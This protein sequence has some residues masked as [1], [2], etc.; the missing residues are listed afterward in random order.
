MVTKGRRYTYF[1]PALDDTELKKYIDEFSG[2]VHS[3]EDYNEVSGWL[4]DELE[5]GL[6]AS[7]RDAGRVAQVPSPERAVRAKRYLD[8]D[9]PPQPGLAAANLHLLEVG[10][11]VQKRL[12]T[13]REARRVEQSTDDARNR[14]AQE[15]WNKWVAAGV[16]ML[17]EIRA[18][19]LHDAAGAPLPY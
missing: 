3:D 6:L 2:F 4:R 1:E 7:A 12:R 10:Q 17:K 14:I 11:P 5:G 18:P 19:V 8:L 13:G 9:R 16:E 15:E